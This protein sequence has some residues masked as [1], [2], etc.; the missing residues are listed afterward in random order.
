VNSRPCLSLLPVAVLLLGCGYPQAGLQR[1]GSYEEA[2]ARNRRLAEENNL[3][4]KEVEGLKA[5]NAR[6]RAKLERSGGAG[7]AGGGK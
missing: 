6:L 4:R 5:D 3:L 2:A 7:D 1:R